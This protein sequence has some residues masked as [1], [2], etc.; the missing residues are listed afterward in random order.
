MNASVISIDGKVNRQTSM[1]K[2]FSEVVRPDIIKRAVL[3]EN[4]LSVQPQG[5]YLL[6]GMQ[7][8]ASYH[9]RMYTWRS[10]RRTGRAQRPRE[11]LGGGRQGKV[12]KIPSAVK[13]RRAHPHHVEKNLTEQMNKREYQKAIMSAIAAT[14]S[15]Y[16]DT[17]FID[18]AKLPIVVSNEIESISKAKDF[19]AALKAIGLDKYIDES[20]ESK[21]RASNNKRVSARSRYKRS[22]LLVLGP[23]E[24]K[25]EKAARNLPGVDVCTSEEIRASLLAPGGNPGRITIWSENA[26][27]ALDESSKK[28]SLR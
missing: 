10:G 14:A 7:T 5:H 19:M 24:K 28:W 18:K 8:S 16:V 20:H 12:K 26:I 25:A 13:G 23:G 27:L 9:G 15:D 4:A 2:A 1:P 6:A 21:R 3:A 11:H 22:V 17:K